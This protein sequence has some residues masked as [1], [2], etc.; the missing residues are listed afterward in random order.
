MY[1]SSSFSFKLTLVANIS[2]ICNYKP[3][4]GCL[5]DYKSFLP[6]ATTDTCIYSCK[7]DW[8]GHKSQM[9]QLEWTRFLVVKYIEQSHWNYSFVSCWQ[10]F[11]IETFITYYFE[12]WKGHPPIFFAPLYLS[13][14]TPLCACSCVF[15]MP[16]HNKYDYKYEYIFSHKRHLQLHVY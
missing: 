9:L 12:I 1:F 10:S 13:F 15:I 16:K 14:N 5:C 4:C 6:S 7:N 2:C 8:F 11:L 3:F